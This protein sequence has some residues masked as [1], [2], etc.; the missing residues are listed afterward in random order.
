MNEN[1]LYGEYLRNMKVKKD[2]LSIEDGINGYF[3]NKIGLNFT[4]ITWVGGQNKVTVT[5]PTKNIRF[6]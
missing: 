4:D 5:A 3:D 2:F 6:S 1:V